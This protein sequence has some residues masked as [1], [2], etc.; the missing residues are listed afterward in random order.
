MD[1]QIKD[2][3]G[4]DWACLCSHYQTLLDNCYANCPN[5]PSEFLVCHLHIHRTLLI[6]LTKVFLPLKPPF[7]STAPPT[8][9]LYPRA[10]PWLLVVLLLDLPLPVRHRLP[11]LPLVAPV[12]HLP[13]TRPRAP[14][15]LVLGLR[16]PRPIPMVPWLGS[17]PLLVLSCNR[18]LVVICDLAREF[19]FSLTSWIRMFMVYRSTLITVS[20]TP[21]QGF[22]TINH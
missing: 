20:M 18:R 9:L 3:P 8:P 12:L 16:S 10:A 14:L 17:W 5:D 7:F 4:N 15:L 6:V 13:A 22:F 1:A 21:I 19:L 11:L 2:C